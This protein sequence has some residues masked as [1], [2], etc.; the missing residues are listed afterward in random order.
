MTKA[1]CDV[2]RDSGG[3]ADPDPEWRVTYFVTCGL[4]RREGERFQFFWVDSGFRGPVGTGSFGDELVESLQ[5]DLLLGRV[6]SLAARA[7]RARAGHPPSRK[8]A[9]GNALYRL[10]PRFAVGAGHGRG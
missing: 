4:G 10:G 8:T 2:S 9:S 5:G 6:E 3:A 7:L 1:F